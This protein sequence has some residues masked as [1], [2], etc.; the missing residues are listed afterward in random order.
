MAKENQTF[1]NYLP[2]YPIPPGDTLGDILEAKS[3]SQ[4][5]LARRMNRPVQAINEILNVKKTITAQTAQ[6]LERVLGLPAHFWLHLEQNFQEA[7][8]RSEETER[9]KTQVRQLDG[10][11]YKELVLRGLLPKIQD[12]TERVSAILNWLGVASIEALNSYLDKSVLAYRR[13]PKFSLERLK[14]AAWLRLGERELENK[15]IGTFKANLLRDRLIDIRRIMLSDI[16]E[17][18]SQLKSKCYECGVSILFI[19][20]LKG[21]P[22]SG[23][24][25]WIGK[26]PV[27]QLTLRGK[28]ADIFWFTIFHEIGHILKHKSSDIFIDVERANSQNDF[29]KEAD[30]FAADTLI[31]QNEYSKIVNQKNLSRQIITDWADKLGILPGIILG[32]LQHDKIV[33]P[34]QFNDLHLYL[35]KSKI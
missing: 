16:S 32:R 30:K 22:V 11:P 33:K 21:F 8:A 23:I 7:L 14:L 19:N 5:E 4:L 6:Q 18:R 34:N 15:E 31:P 24:T 12:V 10:F 9:L 13:S 26:N 27:I 1:G 20:E 29:E 2:P 28:R 25:R 3:M 17:W 35:T